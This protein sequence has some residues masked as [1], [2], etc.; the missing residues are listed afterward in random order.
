[1]FIT[2]QV[3]NTRAVLLLL[4]QNNLNHCAAICAPPAS[5]RTAFGQTKGYLIMSEKIIGYCNPPKANQF[6]PGISG[7][8]SGR[9]KKRK[10]LAAEIAETLDETVKI[11]QNGKT[12]EVTNRKA[13]ALRLIGR[14]VEGDLKA[15]T[16]LISFCAEAGDDTETEIT[17]LSESDL[18]L[19][20]RSKARAS[21]A[22]RNSEEE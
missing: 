4:S 12:T 13:F 18:Q 16:A 2:R 6:R 8:P 22:S 14:A 19:L 15:A 20:Q 9:P 7:N 1:V 11:T 10:T 5:N 17:E 3:R 21:A